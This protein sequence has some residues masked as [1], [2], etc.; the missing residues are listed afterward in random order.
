MPPST[1]STERVD[2][3]VR[4]FNS[5]AHLDECLTSIQRY[6][7][8]HEII[9]VDRN[10][11]D[12]SAEIALEHGA[13]LISEE[14]GL[15]F[16]TTTGI[17]AARTE[18]LLFVDSDVVITGEDFYARALV[19]LSERGTGAV[20]G[21]PVGHRFLY[22]LPLGLTL[23][24]RST[25]L[26]IRFPE[27]LQS[28]ETYAIQREMRSRKLRVRYVL[29]AC[30]HYGTYRKVPYWPEF[31]GAHVKLSSGGSALELV[32]S[33][34]TVLLM[35]MNSGSPRNVL[36]TPVFYA[37]LVRGYLFPDRWKDM[38]RRKIVI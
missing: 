18:R 30:E 34:E 16:A 32:R 21:L 38:D 35:H 29:D 22:G 31:Q 9:V 5:A 3:V 20:V 17:R 33:F 2:V 37:K 14:K 27:E 24:R 1:Q 25:L 11:T 26:P 15:A 13:R 6:I 19:S 12:R 28:R 10:S 7:P 23:F 36:Y 8:Y 4:T